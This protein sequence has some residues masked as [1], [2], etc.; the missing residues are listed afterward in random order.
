MG[1]AL[2]RDEHGVCAIQPRG[3]DVGD[4]ELAAIGAGAG[5]GHRQHAGFVV[6]QLRAA[7]IL[8]AVAGVATA[9][10]FRAAALDHEIGDHAM[11]SEERRVGNECV[12]TCK[13]RWSPYH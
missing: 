4:E 10:A 2:H 11:S 8:E 9:T 5:I 13:S 6:A 7:L 1:G 12:S 3:G